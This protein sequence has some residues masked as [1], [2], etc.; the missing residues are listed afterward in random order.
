[1]TSGFD[2]MYTDTVTETDTDN[3]KPVNG[4]MWKCVVMSIECRG[5]WSTNALITA[6]LL[7]SLF[8]IY[9]C[10]LLYLYFLL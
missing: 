2:Y 8:N 7:Y 6:I 1:M 5:R 10:I 3:K 9:F 4:S